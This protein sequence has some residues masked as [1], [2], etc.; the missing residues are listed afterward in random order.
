MRKAL[1]VLLGA[2]LAVTLSGGA[3]SGGAKKTIKQQWDVVAAPFPGAD[4]HS[5]PSEECGVE[6]VS[7][8]IHSFKTPARGTLDTRINRF[9]GEWDLYVTDA[10]GKLLGSS[11]KFMSTPEERVVVKLKANVKVDI[12]ACNFLGGPTA[13]GELKYTYVRKSGRHAHHHDH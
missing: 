5:D 8:A 6:G 12:Y 2:C 7:Y 3:A 4:D 1:S 11:V 13:H 9:E 10:K